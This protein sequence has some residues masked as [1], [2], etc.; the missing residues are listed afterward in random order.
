MIWT[1]MLTALLAILLITVGALVH[2][3]KVVP[4]PS[5]DAVVARRA[6]GLMVVSGLLGILVVVTTII[7]TSMSL[8]TNAASAVRLALALGAGGTVIRACWIV[9]RKQENR[10]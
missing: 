7:Q 8:P 1:Q 2:T 4:N 10:H 5:V 9:R 3:R 6:G